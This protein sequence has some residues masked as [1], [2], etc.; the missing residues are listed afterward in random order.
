M[1]SFRSANF[2]PLRLLIQGL[3]T[4]TPTYTHPPHT[5]KDTGL[6]KIHIQQ[7]I[8][9]SQYV[10]CGWDW[11]H[12]HDKPPLSSH[13][14]LA[15]TSFCCARSQLPFSFSLATMWSHLKW[16]ISDGILA[17]NVNVRDRNQGL[18]VQDGDW[19]QTCRDGDLPF[20]DLRIRDQDVDRDL[21]FNILKSSRVEHNRPGLAVTRTKTLTR[22]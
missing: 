17:S 9:V 4:H 15:S 22:K 13:H 2:A 12:Y 20:W 14:V 1:G 10:Y 5:Q 18:I 8:F 21:I 19:D 16:S 6:R 11:N 7:D 3:H